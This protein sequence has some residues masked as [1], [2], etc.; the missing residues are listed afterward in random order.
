MLN[1]KPAARR[2]QR[3]TTVLALA[4]AKKSQELPR[5]KRKKAGIPRAAERRVAF[6]GCAKYSIAMQNNWG[7]IG[8]SG[9]V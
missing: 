2:A 1:L 6:L 9:H 7:D 3:R 5:A 4:G 8:K